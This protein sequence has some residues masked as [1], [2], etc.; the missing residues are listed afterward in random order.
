VT[1]NNSIEFCAQFVFNSSPTT[2]FAFDSVFNSLQHLK[3]PGHRLISEAIYITVVEIP[4]T[5]QKK[6][7]D[8]KAM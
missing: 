7:V 6:T 8:G 4:A 5:K 1:E 2:F 3:F